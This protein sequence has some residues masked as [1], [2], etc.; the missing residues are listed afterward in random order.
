MQASTRWRFSKASS[1]ICAVNTE[2][3][4][5]IYRKILIF[6]SGCGAAL[7]AYL[8]YQHYKPAGTSFCD[9]NNYISCDIVNQSIYSE[10]AGVPVAILGLIAYIVLFLI[11]VR[12]TS[13][14]STEL[15]MLLSAGSFLFS[16]YLTYLEF[17][18]L[19]AICLLCLISQLI[20]L[21][22]FIISLLLWRKHRNS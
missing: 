7:S 10:I 21:L 16:L 2:P 8:V 1:S 19:Y 9:I 6:L 3:I 12:T 14:R 5:A 18:V 15:L 17:F 4:N 13:K 11:A 20:I 22:F